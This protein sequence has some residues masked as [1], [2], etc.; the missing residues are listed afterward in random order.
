LRGS[1]LF[2]KAAPFDPMVRVSDK[3]MSPEELSG[4]GSYFSQ[5]LLKKGRSGLDWEAYRGYI[6]NLHEAN[7]YNLVDVDAK[8]T[9]AQVR[10][11]VRPHKEK[12]PL[13]GV[14]YQP[15]IDYWDHDKG[16]EISAFDWATNITNGM[17]LDAKVVT[18]PALLMCLLADENK[19]W[20]DLGELQGPPRA[21]LSPDEI[22]QRKEAANAEREKQMKLADEIKK[23]FF[24]R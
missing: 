1:W 13:P 19:V 22:G 24:K 3:R 7:P 14:K 21:N 17:M 12:K 23:S 16:G 15:S 6:G 8:Q 18:P 9:A 10:N 11:A 5:C 2:V 20:A 4:F